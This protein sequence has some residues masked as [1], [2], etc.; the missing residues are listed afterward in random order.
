[1]QALERWGNTQGYV[2]WIK[3]K[4]GLNTGFVVVILLIIAVLLLIQGLVGGFILFIIGV[5]VPSYQSFLAIESPD[6]DDD[7]RMLNFWCI[8]S[9]FLVVDKLLEPVMFIIPLSGLLRFGIILGL[10]VNNYFGSNFI[11][12]LFVSPLLSAYE[13]DIDNVYTKVKESIPGVSSSD[14]PHSH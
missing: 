4:T 9:I 13:R 10:V 6:K 12:S 2:R 11:Y 3:N 14:K 8:F 7:T 5:I 1:M